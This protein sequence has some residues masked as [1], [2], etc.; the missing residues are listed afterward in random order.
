VK[1]EKPPSPLGRT[2]A[3]CRFLV[4]SLFGVVNTRAV[5]I[6]ERTRA[7]GPSASP[8]HRRRLAFGHPINA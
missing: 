5:S 1:S 4:V 7:F 8:R 6:V 2:S 3:H